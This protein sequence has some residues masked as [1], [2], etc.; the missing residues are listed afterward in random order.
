MRKDSFTLETGTAEQIPR[1]KIRK[2]AS[3]AKTETI[4]RTLSGIYEG[5]AAVFT[6]PAPGL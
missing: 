4:L 5:F 2:T 3:P 1:K 6:V